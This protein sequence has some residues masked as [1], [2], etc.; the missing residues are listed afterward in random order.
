MDIEKT[1]KELVANQLNQKS[2]NIKA[3]NEFLKD[4]KAD[5][6]D[7]V[8]LIMSFEEQFDIQIADEDAEKML[9][10]QNAVDYIKKKKS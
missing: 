10:V 5:S 2:E 8:E 1:I 9:T 6:L 3:E 7:V 4:L